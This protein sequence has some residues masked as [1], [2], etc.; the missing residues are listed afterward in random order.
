[1]N[2]KKVNRISTIFNVVLLVTLLLIIFFGET[3]GYAA[4]PTKN[5]IGSFFKNGIV[6]LVINCEGIIVIT[7]ILSLQI[8]SNNA[9]K[10]EVVT[11]VSIE[12]PYDFKRKSLP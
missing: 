12:K 11:A 8:T 9:A 2:S 4:I 5:G 6:D 10:F 7:S 1:M 3:I